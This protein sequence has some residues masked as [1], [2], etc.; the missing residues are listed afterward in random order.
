MQGVIYSF[1]DI[2]YKG[3]SNSTTRLCFGRDSSKGPCDVTLIFLV[4]LF[5]LKFLTLVAFF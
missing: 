1:H 2:S 4:L 3:L 5:G